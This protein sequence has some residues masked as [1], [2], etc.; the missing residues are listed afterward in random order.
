[1]TQTSGCFLILFASVVVCCRP[2]IVNVL[3]L[4]YDFMADC[5]HIRETRPLRCLRGGGRWAG[6]ATG[7][8]GGAGLDR[9]GLCS[10]REA[11]VTGLVLAYLAGVL[12]LGSRAQRP[13]SSIRELIGCPEGPGYAHR[14]APASD[15]YA[16]RM[17]LVFVL[18]P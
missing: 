15:A 9:A 8:M 12:Q 5:K 18:T 6:P 10:A 17:Y 4:L 2:V 1:M 14:L 7:A 11:L 13:L 16:T 3:T